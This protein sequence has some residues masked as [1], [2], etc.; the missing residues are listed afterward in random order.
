M[1]VVVVNG[2]RTGLV[3]HKITVQL[4]NNPVHLW[5]VFTALVVSRW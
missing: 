2:S 3:I 1:Q 5:C 4:V